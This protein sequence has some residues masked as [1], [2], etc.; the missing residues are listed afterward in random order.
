MVPGALLSQAAGEKVAACGPTADQSWLC[1]T[2]YEIT[3]SR[4]AAELADSVAQPAQILLIVV[5][6]AVAIRLS[7]RVIRRAAKHGIETDHIDKLRR[8]AGLDPLTPIE[9][10]RRTS[11]LETLS[12]VFGH[13]VGVAIWIVTGLV[14]L[15]ELGVNLAPLLAGA[16]V[17]GIVIGFG[18]QTV[19]RDYLSGIAMV[20]EDQFG[21]GDV[22]DVGD[23]SGV[24]ESISLRVTRL[25]D[26]HGVVWWVPNGEIKRVGNLSQQWS[27]ALLDVEVAY[28]TDLQH[29]M[30]TIKATADGLWRDHDEEWRDRILSEPE[31][32]GVE[33]FNA[34]SI[35]LRL[36]VQTKPLEQ[37]AVARELRVRLKRAFDEAG[38]EIPFPQR[39]VTLRHAGSGPA[40]T[41]PDEPADADGD[42]PAD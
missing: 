3:G 10:R 9:R 34:D 5:L 37:W 29:A 22:I 12:S 2:V 24:V 21:V 13:V 4:D 1:S 42:E 11:R 33:A 6:A 18:A 41:S 8:R 26:V 14:L 7:R 27:R 17:V 16:G 19:V 35:V 38:I 36:V 40:L 30:S 15:G 31:M 23:A 39:T 32:W 28:D 20:V 25:R